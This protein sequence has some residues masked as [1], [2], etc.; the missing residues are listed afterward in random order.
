MSTDNLAKVTAK[1]AAEV[2]ARFALA[3]DAQALLADKL[4]PKQFLDLL[5]AREQLPDAVKLLAYALPKR[6]AVWWASQCVR[7]WYGAEPPAADQAALK[8][9]E[10]W[11]ADP[12]EDNRKATFAAGDKAGFSTPAGCVALAAYW[13]GGTHAPPDAKLDPPPDAWT[14]HAVSGAVL[15]AAVSDDAKAPERYRDYLGLGQDVARGAKR[16]A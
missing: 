15:A 13:S 1:T 2:C 3:P 5:V 8:A 7:R 10:R 6:E 14:G 9:A 4:T 16:W 12:S 11:V